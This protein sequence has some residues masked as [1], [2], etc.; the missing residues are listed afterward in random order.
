MAKSF[1]SAIYLDANATEPLRPEAREAT[2]AALEQGGNPSS[3]H[4]VGRAAR[5]LL[6]DARKCV[7]RFADRSAECCVFT[8]GG[9]EADT[10]AIHALGHSI[11]RQVLIGATEHDAV[12]KAAPEAGIV[13][14]DEQGIVKLDVL[15]TMLDQVPSALVC[16]MAANNETGVCAPLEDVAAIC[17][18]KGAL[19]HIDAVQSAGR[20]C[21]SQEAMAG[22]SIALSGHK[23]G[24]PKGAGALL[25][26]DDAPLSPLL[27]GGGQERG[28]RGGTPALPAIMGMAAALEASQTQDWD[29]IAQWRDD[30]Q[31]RAQDVEAEIVA[32][33]VTRLPNTLNLILP[34]VSS[35]TQLMMLDLEGFCVSSGSACSSGKVSASHVLQAMGFREQAGQALRISLP[36][37]V[38]EE[39]VVAFAEAYQRM[40]KR[41]KK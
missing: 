40:A 36:W 13:P 12:R 11:G 4:A 5:A 17:R 37:N 8:S 9:T 6:E 20:L 39:E 10:L 24:G 2:M 19:L 21:L 14:V 32:A 22:A 3:V 25:L 34:G 7:A 35:Q 1:S 27:P 16:I 33:N 29:K 41:L 38:T 26:P 18:E 23:L 28:R 30:V 31:Q 15:R